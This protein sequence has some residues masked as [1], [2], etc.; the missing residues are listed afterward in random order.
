MNRQIWIRLKNNSVIKNNIDTL[1]GTS[2]E[3]NDDLD[4][5]EVMQKLKEDMLLEDFDS[6]SYRLEIID[7]SIYINPR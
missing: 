6:K 1:F 5:D 2:F 3:L 7:D 4:I